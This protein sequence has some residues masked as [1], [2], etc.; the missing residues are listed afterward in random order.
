MMT[1][2]DIQTHWAKDCIAQLVDRAIVRG[3]PDGSFKPDNL[4]T[5][6]EFAILLTKAFPNTQPIRNAIAFK[7]VP[8]THWA[9]AAIQAATRAGFFSGYP[10]G[11]FK[12]SLPI[13]RVQALVALASGLQIPS[14]PNPNEVLPQYLDDAA[15]VPNYARRAVASSLQRKLVV[16]YPQVRRLNPEFNTSRGDV[17]ALLCRA[18]ALPG[19]PYQYVPGFV[20][21]APTFDAADNFIQGLAKV[22][23]GEKWGY[24]EPSGKIVIPAQYDEAQSFVEGVA[25]V[26]SQRSGWVEKQP[27]TPPMEMRGIWITT[28]ASRVLFSRDN[29][30]AAVNFLADTGFNTI[31]PVVWNQGATM[32]PSQ[33]MKDTC[34][35]EIDAR[36]AGRDPLKELVEEAKNVGLAVIPWFEY[37]FASSYSQKGGRI[38]Q[39]K[40]NWAARD[41][42]GNL[43]TKNSFDWLNAFD[44]EVQ[45]FLRA[46]M[47]EVVNHYEI[48][49]IQGDDRFPALPSEGGYDPST[50]QRYTQQ[51]GQAPPQNPKDP[52][53]VQWRSDLLTEFLMSLYRDVISL[54]PNLLLSLSPSVYPWGYQEYLQDSQ[55]W[56][57]RGLVD[58]IHPQAYRRNFIEYKQIIDR[59]LVEQFTAK[60]KPLLSPGVLVKAATY[61]ISAE[62]L[63]Q[64]IEYNRSLGLP[65]EVLFFYEG[66]REENDTLAKA[67]KSGPYAKPAPFD[68][69]SL[70]QYGFTDRRLNI[71]YSY[72]DLS[73]APIVQPACDEA[74][75]YS[76]NIAPVKQGYKW[77]YL[78][79]VG[80]PITRYEYDEA[81]RFSE[82]LAKVK[83]GKKYGYLNPLGQRVI[84]PQFDDAGQFTFVPQPALP[85]PVVPPADTVPPGNTTPPGNTNPSPNPAPPGN[86]GSPSPT[87]SPAPVEPPPPLPPIEALAPVKM[88]DRWGYILKNGTVFIPAQFDAAGSFFEGLARVK[89]AEVWGYIDPIG[90]QVIPLKFQD[91]GDFSEEFAAV[92]LDNKWGYIDKL[93]TVAIAPQ[94][95]DA[96]SFKNGVATVKIDRKWG[97]I[98]KAG[99]FIVLPDFDE[100]NPF[101]EGVA[102]VK[103]GEK[104]GYI[105]L[106]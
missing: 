102:A 42:K 64:K 15:A 57:D 73:G 104:W 47:L 91:V 98:N 65:G 103:T 62:H 78:N 22:R 2:P 18:L 35:V 31:F 77:A 43:L 23:V 81:D 32:Y 5:R 25:L 1:F 55:S 75:S 45:G 83:V 34:G 70:K 44:P 26:R 100:A 12:P 28:T 38:I 52:Q 84:P 66:L 51:F 54:N 6:A 80:Q 88:G 96:R 4:V 29:I 39:S 24:I 92:K 41:A 19:V 49:G 17:A 21:I 20:A 74:Q 106:S 14:H 9:H 58:T 90:Q 11:T 60:Q 99:Q 69:R 50:V 82:G 13:P 68:A 93:G 94:F 33:V 48:Q 71:K 86:T 53:W 16:N 89:L 56:V 87:P 61:R 72:L 36:F 95:E 105:Q 85:L 37:G 30:K 40:P 79:S 8:V 59:L 97:Y 101:M 67:L 63:I 76:G 27:D 10:D 46:M 7:D 3:Y